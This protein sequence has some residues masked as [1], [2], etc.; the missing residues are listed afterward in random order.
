M[1]QDNALNSLFDLLLLFVFIASL[2]FP[3]LYRI[4][5][6]YNLNHN[7]Q[8]TSFKT[9]AGYFSGGRWSRKP[10]S[11]KEPQDSC[12]LTLSY[13]FLAKFLSLFFLEQSRQTPQEKRLLLLSS[14]DSVWSFLALAGIPRIIPIYP[15]MCQLGVLWKYKTLSMRICIFGVLNP[16][17][18]G[19][20][21]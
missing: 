16:V 21:L 19:L 14:L 15:M 9:L 18:Q 12:N 17:C 4:G 5:R 2:F 7:E 3:P 10:W 11:Q 6:W 8:L 13:L 1:P 20:S